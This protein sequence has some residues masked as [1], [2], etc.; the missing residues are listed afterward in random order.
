MNKSTKYNLAWIFMATLAGCGSESGSVGEGADTVTLKSGENSIGRISNVGEVD[1]YKYSPLTSNE[2][3]SINVRSNVLRADIEL[4]ASAYI[5]NEQG[6]KIRLYADHASENSV[7]RA[8]LDLNFLVKD[9]SDIYLSVRDLRDDA[10]DNFEYIVSIDVSQAE[11]ESSSFTDALSLNDQCQ[12]DEISALGDTDSF[13]LNVTEPSVVQF[14]TDFQKKSGSPVDL[15]IKLYKEDGSLIELLSK[16]TGG[17]TLYPM[18][19]F[20]TQG[21]YFVLVEDAGRNNFDSYSPF[22]VCA[23]SVS[24]DEVGGNDTIDQA[25]NVSL[26]NGESVITGSLDYNQDTDWYQLDLPNKTQGDFQV[27]NVTFDS[28]DALA[29]YQYEVSVVDS[30][31]VT[32]MTHIH[33]S[34]SQ[35]YNSQLKVEGDG[36]YYL[37][38]TPVGQQVY[39]Q[40]ND[41]LDSGSNPE[42]V[43][44]AAYEARVSAIEVDDI[45]EV[46]QGNDSQL[47]ATELVSGSDWTL[48]KIAYRTDNDWY[49]ITV[50]NSDYQILEVF[51]ESEN[52]SSGG[53]VEY[54]LAV[55]GS[56]VERTLEDLVGSDGPTHLKTS[57]LVEPNTDIGSSV[58]FIRVRDFQDDDSD[59]QSGY[60]IKARTFNVPNTFVTQHGQPSGALYWDEKI[61]QANLSAETKISLEAEATLF[62]RQFSSDIETLVFDGAK[63]NPLFV[64]THEIE[65]TTFTSPWIGGY[66][67]YQG[68]QDWLKLNLA[69][70]SPKAQ[71]DEAG[72]VLL[73]DNGDVLYE[74]Q[75][76]KWYYDLKVEMQSAGSTVEYI[77]KMHYDRTDNQIVND[78]ISKT[79]DGVFASNGDTDTQVNALDLVSGGDGSFWRNNKL[80]GAYYLK[81]SDYNVTD[82]QKKYAQYQDYDWGYDQPYYVRLTL[83]Y[84][85]GLSAKP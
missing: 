24:S 70:L 17:G 76:E 85:T 28:S 58:Y 60:R 67:D 68:D 12:S 43:S 81:V 51:L 1:W 61:E 18:V 57:I 7:T 2:V 14:T 49:K 55:I 38:I 4:L 41:S 6:E 62:D 11:D 53:A 22:T 83:V 8:N 75:D 42:Y 48:G 15:R 32:I 63:A 16:P 73:D 52:D 78:S 66:V 50:H 47:T 34:A 13:V 74:A 21:R 5:V 80:A 20:L 79:G 71:T 39:A 69:P 44:S 46:A 54:S 59:A 26:S 19:H 40:S 36:P 9:N 77:W 37:K 33:N 65:G 10:A 72:V 3:I 27:L 23:K 82:S 29:Y 64:K 25:Q 35:A 31:G 30:A 84:H 45:Q 56:E